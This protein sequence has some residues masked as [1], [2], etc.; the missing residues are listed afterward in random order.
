M[1]FKKFRAL[2]TLIQLV[3][4]VTITIIGMYIFRKKNRSIR[5][6]WAKLEL[7]LLGIT[8]EIK[9]DIDPDA[10]ML[11]INHQSILDIILLE[12]LHP[13]DLCW[14]AKKEIADIFWFGHILKAPNM[15]VV[16][17]ESKSSLVKL[18]KDAK[19]RFDQKRPIAIFPEGTRGDGTKLKKFRVGAKIIA[20]K[21]NMLV[22]PIIIT[23]SRD[24]FD[25]QKF[26]QQSGVVTITYL[27]S[28]KATKK[29]T[30]YE[31][32]EKLMNNTLEIEL[33]S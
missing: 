3:I 18:I 12:A 13:R 32:T 11:M 2:L 30:W 10:D 4:T 9:G 21:N 23:K 5:E 31:D 14:V 33:N 29:S 22:Q 17:R 25:S 16:E 24:I 26:L 7:F 19:N 15:I 6:V 28:I 1:I 27:P 20:E 8:L